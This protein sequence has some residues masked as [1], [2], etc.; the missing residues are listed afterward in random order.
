MSYTVVAVTPNPC[1]KDDRTVHPHVHDESLCEGE[2][3]A[4]IG[5]ALSQVRLLDFFVLVH[6][7]LQTDNAGSAYARLNEWTGNPCRD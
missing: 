1:E 2:G 7:I 4:A 5:K 3:E 6:Q